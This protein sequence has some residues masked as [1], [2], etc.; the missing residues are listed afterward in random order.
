MAAQC[1]SVS[2]S[3]KQSLLLCYEIAADEY[4]KKL[5]KA[6]NKTLASWIVHTDFCLLLTELTFQQH[7]CQFLTLAQNAALTLA[8][9]VFE[10]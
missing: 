1:K 6:K 5:K 2:S 10:S 8:L 4:I 9:L 7:H 3:G